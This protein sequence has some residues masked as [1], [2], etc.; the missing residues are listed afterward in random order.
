MD[1]TTYDNSIYDDIQKNEI[2]KSFFD[3]LTLYSEKFYI[4]EVE[5]QNIENCIEKPTLENILEI[6]SK[7]K[8]ENINVEFK[9]NDIIKHT[10]IHLF[11]DA[12]FTTGIG[13]EDLE[14]LKEKISFGFYEYYKMSPSDENFQKFI[15]N[16][17]KHIK[18]FQKILKFEKQGEYYP[19]PITLYEEQ[20]LRIYKELQRHSEFIN[21]LTEEQAK[22]LIELYEGIKD[23]QFKYFD[24]KI[25]KSERDKKIKQNGMFYEET[26]NHILN[27]SLVEVDINIIIQNLFKVL[28]INK[29]ENKKGNNEKTSFNIEVVDWFIKYK[30]ED[31]NKLYNRIFNDF[32][33]IITNYTENTKTKGGIN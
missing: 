33:F 19:K 11:S 3:K 2:L 23:Y 28:I 22:L 13:I 26:L 21:G 18:K 16:H 30:N 29:L 5:Q 31:L 6:T 24:Y 10:S 17:S 27:I 1:F 20:K 12:F 15:I 4:L 32:G 8:N 7:L 14:F 9:E 25:K